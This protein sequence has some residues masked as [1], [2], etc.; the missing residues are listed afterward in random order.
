VAAALLA[1]LVA[2]VEIFFFPI[3]Q[4]HKRSGFGNGGVV[5]LSAGDE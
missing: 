1:S 4:I 2:R 3:L 5:V